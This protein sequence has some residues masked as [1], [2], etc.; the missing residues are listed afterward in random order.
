M[1]KIASHYCLLPDGSL[2]KRPIITLDDA[3]KICDV[4]LLNDNFQEE[5]GTAYSGGII[6]PAFVEDG[7]CWLGH[8]SEQSVVDRFLA[9]AFRHGSLRLIVDEQGARRVQKYRG[10]YS[11]RECD[12]N[13]H[14]KEEVCQ[15]GWERIKGLYEADNESDMMILV[16]RYFTN[17]LAN[18]Y[19]PSAWGRIA[20]GASP[21]LLLIQGLDLKERRLTP[22]VKLKI[23]V[24]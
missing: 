19:L 4:R 14:Q 10:Q 9:N 23:L 15:S 24:S 22:K 6:I 7:R 11:V 13:T 16:A 5:P 8:V 20:V 3:G 1:R 17:L 12:S 18:E 2:G 21:G